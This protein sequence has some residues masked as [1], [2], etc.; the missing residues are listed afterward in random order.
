MDLAELQQRARK[1]REFEHAIDDCGFTL[2]TPTR[3]ELRQCMHERGLNPAEQSGVVLSLLQQY[4][5]ERYLIG[6]KGVRD[7]HVLPDAGDAP[8]P[9]S[10]D[11]VRLVLDA[12]PEWADALGAR[13]LASVAERR[14]GLE[15]D[16]KN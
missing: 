9:W 1:A 2:R 5:L 12:Q 4:L 6:W 8:L 13:L 11:A 14:A 3:L 16:A 15:A 10:A 7:R